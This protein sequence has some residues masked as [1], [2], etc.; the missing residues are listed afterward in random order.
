MMSSQKVSLDG[1]WEFFYSPIKFEAEL[2]A[3]P[4]RKEFSGR[5]VTPGYWDD[6]YELF[7]EEDYFSLLAR[8]NPDYRKPHFP[9]GTSLLPHASSSFLIG[10]GYYRKQ[11]LM[12]LSGDKRAFLTIGPAMWGCA[13]FCNGKL[14][15]KTTGYS[16]CS[17]FEITSLVRNK[18]FNEIILVVCNVHDDGGAYCRIDGSHDG[19]PFGAR[20]GQHR[21]LAAQGFQSERAGIGDQTFIRITGN[22]AITDA[23]VTFENEQPHWHAEFINGKGKT[24]RWSLLDGESIF[25]S[26]IYEISGDSVD[27]LSAPPQ[28]AGQTGMRN[29]IRS[30]W[31]LWRRISYSTTG[32]D[33]GEP[34]P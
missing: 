26:G 10:S 9:M 32:N 5:M 7:D 23:W 31:N 17:E 3:L 14:A 16:V 29:F 8:F 22:A 24:L 1:L 19:T 30:D 25:D 33:P 12:D 21:G 15:G 13:V 27:F 28:S 11:I 4:D 20:P 6:H 2:T 18:E 34:E